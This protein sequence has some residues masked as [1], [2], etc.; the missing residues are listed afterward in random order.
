MFFVIH[1]N[2]TFRFSPI[3]INAIVQRPSAYLTP[4]ELDV[5]E[6]FLQV[7]VVHQ[8]EL[9]PINEL[10]THFRWGE[11]S[12]VTF[13]IVVVDLL[14]FLQANC[15]NL[16]Q[17]FIDIQPRTGTL[18]HGQPLRCQLTFLAQQCGELA[19]DW[20]VP[21]YIQNAPQ[22]IFLKLKATMKGMN[23]EFR[24]NEK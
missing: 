21:C 13:I 7:P 12:I 10:P 1:Q 23:I 24:H 6:T 11:V 19:D 9:H 4:V 3:A 18:Y 17:C 15:E 20:H 5:G 14:I 8:F 16:D 2:Q 22:P